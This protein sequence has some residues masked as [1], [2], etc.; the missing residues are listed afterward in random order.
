LGHPT[1]TRSNFEASY[2]SHHGWLAPGIKLFRGLGFP[3]KSAWVVGA[4]LAPVVILLTQLYQSGIAGVETAN[5]ER[6]GIRYVNGVTAL[7]HDLI[8]LRAAA[9]TK[10]PELKQ[11]QASV[12]TAF[13]KV[14][15]LEKEL[16][17]VFA[18][19][20]KLCRSDL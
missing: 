6:Q 5:Q 14:Q 2:F 1:E 18:D 15:G 12:E 3:A 4:M 16:G 8:A 17:H 10:S 20:T 7:M 11:K 9:I 19:E 13:V